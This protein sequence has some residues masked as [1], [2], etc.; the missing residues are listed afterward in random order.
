MATRTT[1][2]EI[3]GVREVTRALGDIDKDAKR[4]LDK[5]VREAAAEL[6]TKSRGHVS[7]GLSGWERWKERTAPSGFDPM[8]VSRGI[9]VSRSANRRRGTTTTVLSAA[10]APIFSRIGQELASYL[11]LQPK[12]RANDTTDIWHPRAGNYAKEPSRPWRTANLAHVS[13]FCDLGLYSVTFN[14]ILE[15]DLEAVAHYREFRHD[16]VKHKFRHFLEIFNPNA[17]QNLPAEQM[18]FFV[19][20]MIMR[21]LAGMYAPDAGTVLVHGKDVTGWK[22]QDAIA[23]G[24]GMVHQHFMLVP[25]LT[26]AE[27]VILGMEPR[28]GMQVDLHRAAIEVESLCK[29]CGLHVDAKAKVADLSV[30]EAQR[31]EILKALY[32]GAKILILDEPTNGLDVES[33]RLFYDLMNEQAAAGTT[34]VFSTHIVTDLERV[35]S[36]VW[37]MKAGNID[38]DAP[39]DELKEGYV[40]VALPT[41]LQLSAPLHQH[42]LHR[43]SDHRPGGGSKEIDRFRERGLDRGIDPDVDDPA[44]CHAHPEVPEAWPPL[45]AVLA[46]RARVRWSFVPHLR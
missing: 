32:R 43:R 38:I 44:R 12:A 8:K 16:A 10:T 18:P 46:Y 40:R 42:L 21:V 7:T 14:N 6:V 29:K 3:V 19:N 37:L 26:V 22:T 30:G 35:A 4:I 33:T 9:K 27:N 1:G 45:P 20:D 41:A 25:T 36:R 34:I 15:R 28:K 23:A 17:P 24:V 2:I 13:K 11:A 39:M 31:V 5:G